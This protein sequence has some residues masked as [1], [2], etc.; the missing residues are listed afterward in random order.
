MDCFPNSS[1]PEEGT[2]RTKFTQISFVHF[3]L[4]QPYYSA[5][6]PKTLSSLIKWIRW[7]FKSNKVWTEKAQDYLASTNV[8]QSLLSHLTLQKNY[9]TTSF[10]STCV[11]YTEATLPRGPK[12]VI[13][14]VSQMLKTLLGW[15]LQQTALWI[16]TGDTRPSGEQ[17]INKKRHMLM[18]LLSWM[19]ILYVSNV[20]SSVTPW[21]SN[22]QIYTTGLHAGWTA[23]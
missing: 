23:G 17:T 6:A 22:H 1:P 19:H 11:D 10:I 3:W 12:W 4:S 16:E 14:Q 2:S 15:N 7:L 20:K 13:R 18:L 21:F 9:F 5:A 8:F